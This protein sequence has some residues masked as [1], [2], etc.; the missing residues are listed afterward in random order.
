MTSRAVL[1]WPVLTIL[2]AGCTP[3]LG[4]VLITVVFENEARTQCL[5]TTAKTASGSKISAS[6]ASLPR[7]GKDTLQIGL[8]ET[9][10]LL[11]KVSVTIARF[12]TPDCAGTEFATETKETEVIHGGPLAKLDFRFIGTGATDGGMDGGLGD[13]G[14]DAGC[15]VIACTNA[16][17]QCESLPA[18][19][20][21]MDGGCRYGFKDAGVSCSS[22]V[23][24]SGGT[25]IA[26]LCAV[27]P[28][29]SAC[30][31]GLPCTPNA[32]CGGDMC[33]GTCLAPPECNGIAQPISCD[34]T[35]PTSC[36]LLPNNNYGSCSTAQGGK[37]LDGGCLPWLEFSPLNFPALATSIVVTPYPTAAWTLASP[38]GGLCDTVI[39]TGPTPM[40]TQGDCGTP[41]L[42]SSVNDAGVL[43][44]TTRG[45]EV[46][47]KARLSFVGT[48][49]VQL[50]VIG[51]AT[52]NGIV[53]VAPLIPG[54][55]PAGTASSACA[56]ASAGTTSKQG[57]GGGGFGA[58]GGRGGEN[59][60]AGG[61]GSAMTIPL[62]GGCPGAAGFRSGSNS[63]GGVGG[64][65]I[66]LIIS[67][68]LTMSG[69]A[70]TASGGGGAPGLADFEGGGG[71]GS[72]GTVIIEARV[73]N[74]AGGAVTSNGGGGGE[75]GKNGH[76]S[77][78]F[79]A[80]GPLLSAS[81]APAAST[82]AGGLGGIGGDDG[83]TAGQN[84]GNGGGNEGG[85]GGGGAVGVVFLRA[86]A[87]CM[88]NGGVL[89]GA[90]PM[91][92]G[93]P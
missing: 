13:G 18:S 56:D 79:G 50:V 10:E 78:A 16:V 31:D 42:T 43:V 5:K 20:C 19:G 44:L 11:G 37:C 38:D 14:V 89:S 59:G 32:S 73:I 84:G 23:C 54:Q 9:S 90:R 7:A 26:N 4:K 66:Q 34:T 71:G 91:P 92:F 46:G 68:T 29:G 64:G 51:N 58:V 87:S 63:P 83:T 12:S 21:A 80:T 57:G 22:G 15:N 62:R 86:Q 67:D 72:G 3:P 77:A 81:A 33:Q 93:C 27:L 45:L 24:N 85:G 1:A 6:P 82:G 75:G 28:A 35:T 2:L 36:K 53:S 49:P 52:I 60:G 48:R 47:P 40:V 8:A 39:S 69:G 41:V 88:R 70:V 61:M 55:D 25:C 17:G 30:D 76:P 74:L 65:A